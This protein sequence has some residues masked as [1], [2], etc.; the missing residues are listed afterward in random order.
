MVI[1]F[2]SNVVEV[3]NFDTGLENY[4]IGHAVDN[5]VDHTEIV[6]GVVVVE[7]VVLVVVGSYCIHLC[8][9]G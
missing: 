3:G 5:M 1:D 2:D 4:H 7:V 9:V 8:F 6:V